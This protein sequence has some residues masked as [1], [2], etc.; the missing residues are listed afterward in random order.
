VT[1][2]KA[3]LVAGNADMEYRLQQVYAM[4]VEGETLGKALE[5][6]EVFPTMTVQMIAVGEETAQLSQGMKDLANSYMT[7]VEMALNAFAASI[8]PIIVLG[9]GVI[10]G[11]LVIS[12]ILPTIKVLQSL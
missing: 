10:V 3:A 6:Y 7:D 12:T 9:V 11:F 1:L 8:E 4:I 2:Q 5:V